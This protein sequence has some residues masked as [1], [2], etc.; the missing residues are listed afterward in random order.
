MSSKAAAISSM[1]NTH[2]FSPN[3]YL[4]QRV[5]PYTIAQRSITHHPP[6][7]Q[8][9][10]GMDYYDKRCVALN[11]GDPFKPKNPLQTSYIRGSSR[12]PFKSKTLLQTS[13][14]RGSSGDPFKPKNL[15]QISSISCFV[16]HFRNCKTTLL[17]LF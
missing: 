2:L 7:M 12:N 4:D 13:Y 8:S 9:A 6:K 5:K 14:I 3:F 11:A 1:M 16:N 15:F 10:P 17:T